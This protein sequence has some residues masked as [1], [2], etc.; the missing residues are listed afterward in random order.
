MVTGLHDFLEHM[1]PLPL[2]YCRE[3]K[4]ELEAMHRRALR[5]IARLKKED[6]SIENL[7]N[8]I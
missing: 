3:D 4:D 8:S 7:V 5:V 2:G 1:N 6:P